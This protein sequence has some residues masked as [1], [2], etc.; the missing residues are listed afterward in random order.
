MNLCVNDREIVTTAKRTGFV[1][2]IFCMRSLLSLSKDLLYRPCE[3]FKYVLSYKC[4][5]DHLELTFNA[6][7]GSLGWNTNPSSRQ[8]LYVVRRLHARV[9]IVSD[10]SGNC[11]NF[12]EDH[13]D[14]NPTDIFE[15]EEFH[16][17][18]FVTNIVPYITGFV[19]RKILRHDRC[20]ECREALITSPDNSS[21]LSEDRY[22]LR[23]KNN[24]GLVLPSNDAVCVVR[25][26]EALF[27]RLPLR[28]RSPQTI[29]VNV[30][31]MLSFNVFCSPHMIGEDHR[32]RI[33]RSIVSAYT[34]IRSFYV[35]RMKHL[36]DTSY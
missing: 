13:E 17:S 18:E 19:I 1:G 30:M 34:S 23:M 5:Q 2:F 21:S 33:I 25:L 14:L 20:P 9:G 27:R 12:S 22:F 32:L 28:Q 6:I 26:C 4:S 36:S 31:R 11:V 10:S 35:A 8:L 15:D 29:Y 16:L 7:R 24:G 3:P